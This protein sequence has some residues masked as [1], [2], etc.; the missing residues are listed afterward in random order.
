VLSCAFNTGI[1]ADLLDDG[2]V[3]YTV[4]GRMSTG[5]FGF[6]IKNT[7]TEDAYNIF[8]ANSQCEIDAGF[9]SNNTFLIVEA[10]MGELKDFLIRQLYYPYRLWLSKINKKIVPALITYSN[11]SSIFSCFIYNFADDA[12]YNSIILVDKKE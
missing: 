6:F 8:V 1:I 9:E 2:E 3:H 11:S 5:D 12:D 10:K 7:L 4:S